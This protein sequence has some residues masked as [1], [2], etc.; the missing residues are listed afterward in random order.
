VAYRII[1]WPPLE[2]RSGPQYVSFIMVSEAWNEYT[3]SDS[4]V[5]KTRLI[6]TSVLRENEFS[7]FAFEFEKKTI[8]SAPDSLR[9]EPGNFDQGSDSGS[10]RWESPILL[11]D[12]RWN[13][14]TLENESIPVKIIF[15]ADRAYR[16]AGAFDKYGQPVYC[17][18]GKTVINIS[19][20]EP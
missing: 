7:P 4:V 6:L 12:E 8:V 16:V 19:G 14:Y 17:V 13:E 2:A 9:G 3:F 5:V 10:T 1:I 18:E 20:M 11:R 15:I